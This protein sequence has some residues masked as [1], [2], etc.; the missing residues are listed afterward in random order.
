M[1]E[2]PYLTNREHLI[3]RYGYLTLL[4][5]G[6]HEYLECLLEISRLRKFQAGE[7]IAIEG[8]YDSWAYILLDGEV[9]ILK[10]DQELARLF[11]PGDTFGEQ[12]LID[13]YP[14]SATVEAMTETLCLA[15][16]GDR[17]NGMKNHERDSFNAVFFHLLAETLSG[18]LR[19]S[20]EKILQLQQALDE[21]YGRAS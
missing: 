3:E 18:R 11:T 2:T 10:G 21:H 6:S 7:V 17:V 14:R 15:I 20:N 1:E 5:C 8:E 12:V 9:S 16:D 13:L 19:A 4:G